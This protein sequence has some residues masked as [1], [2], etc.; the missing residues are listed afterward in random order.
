MRFKPRKELDA[1]MSVE[2]S[3][4]VPAATFIMAVIIYMAFFAYTKCVISQD[5]Y[6]LGFRSMLLGKTQDYN[7]AADY[8][9]TKS[10][11]QIGRRYFGTK[12]VDISAREDKEKIRVEGR[13]TTEHSI[14]SGYFNGIP[15]ESGS[16][17]N[18]VI[19][20]RNTYKKIRRAKRVIDISKNVIK[21][22][23]K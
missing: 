1:Y 2:A 5:V 20:K 14:I 6:I 7:N 22:K 15:T 8:V 9:N 3:F 23:K 16:G 21:R 17:A 4:I 10:P 12:N 18:A 19:R 13:F 11:E